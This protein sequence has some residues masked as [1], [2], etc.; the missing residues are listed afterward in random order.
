MA[1]RTRSRTS[2]PR[3]RR[4]PKINLLNTAETFV[5]ANAVTQ[6]MFGTSAYKFLTEGWL[7]PKTSG[8][9]GGAGNSWSLS[10]AEIV[11]GLTTGNYGTASGAWSEKSLGQLIKYNLDGSNPANGGAGKMVGTLILAPIGFK[12]ARQLLRKPITMSNRVLK[13]AGLNKVVV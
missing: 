1:R 4:T 8:S 12:V 5:L 13:M 11:T 2:K 3:T 6:G 9:M 10:A 7:T